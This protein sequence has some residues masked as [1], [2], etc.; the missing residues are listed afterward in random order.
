MVAA[1]PPRAAQPTLAERRESLDALMALGRRAFDDIE[2]VMGSVP[3]AAVPLATR[4]YTPRDAAVHGAGLIYFHGGGLVAGS[5]ASHDSVAR[6]LARAA[7]C[8]VIAVDYRLA[9]EHLFPAA[10]DDAV[11]ATRHVGAAAAAFGMH[12][13]RMGLCGDSAGGALAAAAC[14]ALNAERPLALL[15]LLCPILDYSLQSASRRD[16]AQGF[17]VEE[18]QWRYDLALALPPAMSLDDPRLSPLHGPLP[19]VM[20]R[21]LIHTAE[22]DPMRDDAVAYRD[23]LVRHG[24]DVSYT[25][26]PGMIHLF[27]GLGALIPHADAAFEQIGGQIRQVLAS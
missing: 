27:Y 23:R 25:C 24:T 15:L 12:P 7:G 4:L 2:V 9:P 1:A 8:R 5:L 18:A 26:H 13:G 3:G 17:L 14:Q 19:P 21:T 6:A 20:P 22:Y 16:F 11:A 10:L